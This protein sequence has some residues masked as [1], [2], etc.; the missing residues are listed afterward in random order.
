MWASVG[1]GWLAEAA[2]GAR[3]L[4]VGS[5]PDPQGE[6]VRGP[7]RQGPPSGWRAARPL[8]TRRPAAAWVES[9]RAR[10][11]GDPA[12]TGHLTLSTGMRTSVRTDGRCRLTVCPLQTRAW[13]R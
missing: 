1:L 12:T 10:A 8:Q 4:N 7:P 13:H 11:G 3:R 9:D 5:E 2:L 6:G